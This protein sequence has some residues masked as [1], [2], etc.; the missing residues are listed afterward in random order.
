MKRV[1]L[2]IGIVLLSVGSTDLMA[3]R[4]RGDYGRD[5]RKEVVE[6]KRKGKTHLKGKNKVGVTRHGQRGGKDVYVTQSA[7]KRGKFTPV[8]NR[9]R[10]RSER[11]VD[12]RYGRNNGWVNYGR[13]GT[14]GRGYY[15]YYDYDF[16]RG[17]RIAIHRG[18]RPSNRHIWVGGHWRYD[19][20]L[21]RD[22]WVDGRWSLRRANHRW[23]PGRYRVFNGSRIWVDGCWT[24]V[25]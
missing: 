17:R 5:G 25:Y 24:V 3:Q 2:T 12:Y 16:R 1:L 15:D 8:N 11:V 20:R 4:V 10:G 22:V 13:A 19:P 14:V 18:L 23:A 9:R 6:D 7:R 21:G